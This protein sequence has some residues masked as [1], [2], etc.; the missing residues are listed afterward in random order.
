MRSVIECSIFR[1]PRWEPID[2]LDCMKVSESLL[3]GKR[4]GSIK[5]DGK[6]FEPP[7]VYDAYQVLKK[8]KHSYSAKKAWVIR[9]VYFKGFRVFEK[10]F[11]VI[12]SEEKIKLKRVKQAV[13]RLGL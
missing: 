12:E 4:R 6:I 1:P 11:L 5:V 2:Y 13:K 7:C 9:I 3:N 10:H 8:Y